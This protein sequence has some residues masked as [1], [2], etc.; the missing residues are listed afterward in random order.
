MGREFKHDSYIL[1]DPSTNLPGLND[2]VN[3]FYSWCLF[4]ATTNIW[5]ANSVV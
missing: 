2:E 3:I 4:T 1:Y 5:D